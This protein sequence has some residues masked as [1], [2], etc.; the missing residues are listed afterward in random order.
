VHFLAINGFVS[1]F[2]QRL[3][4]TTGALCCAGNK[5]LPGQRLAD[6]I[7]AEFMVLLA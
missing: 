2:V 7:P 5:L 3:L 6:S 1:G 4:L